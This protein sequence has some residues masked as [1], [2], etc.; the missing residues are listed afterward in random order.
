MAPGNGNGSRTGW[1]LAGILAALMVG[2]AGTVLS[3]FNGPTQ[4][5]VDKIQEQQQ[6]ILIH[7]AA[8]DEQILTLQAK[9]DELKQ[10]L[11]QVRD[12]LEAHLNQSHSK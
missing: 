6:Q 11:D 10:Q 9:Q 4:D 12:L 5:Q 7:L 8:I 2:G 3:S 1:W